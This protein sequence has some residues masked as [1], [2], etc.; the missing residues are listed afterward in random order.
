MPRDRD[1]L[2]QLADRIFLTDGGLE[3]ILVFHDGL[4]LPCFAAFPLLDSQDGRSRLRRYYEEFMDL[5]REHRTGFILETPTWRANRDW[6]AQL[7]YSP[8]DLDAVNRAA[9]ALVGIFAGLA[10][11]RARKED[12]VRSDVTDSDRLDVQIEAYAEPLTALVTLPLAYVG[13]LWWNLAWLTY[14]PIS[15]LLRR[16]GA[17]S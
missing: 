5:A 7:G 11:W 2:P 16:R 15:A 14:I 1:P 12:L 13:E 4:D 17:S 10:W 6:G 3:T 9:V 8:A